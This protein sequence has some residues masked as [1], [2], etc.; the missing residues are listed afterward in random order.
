MPEAAFGSLGG[1]PEIW[2]I[3]FEYI[4]T[5]GNP[6]RPVCC[7]ALEYKSGREIRLWGDQL[8]VAPDFH[9]DSAFVCY[10][11]SAEVGCFLALNW[12]APVHVLD[13]FA[14]F[15]VLTNGESR[16]NGLTGSGLLDALAYFGLSHLDPDVKSHW[17]DRIMAGP[18]YTDVEAVGILDYCASD[19]Y[20]LRELLPRMQ[21]RLEGRPH[22][23]QHALLRGRYMI[24]AAKMES[25]GT[26]V[27][28][29]Q[30]NR[31]IANWEPLKLAFT[32]KIKAEYPI[33][34]G[35]TLKHDLFAGWLRGMR[36]PWPTTPSGRLSLSEDTFKQMTNAYPVIAPI[37]ELRDNLSKL[38]L[39]D[40]SIGQDGRNRTLLSAFRARTGR[41]QPSGTKFIFS[42][43]VWLRALIRPYQGYA[44]AYI[45]F[46]SHEIGIAAA[47]SRDP[48][49]IRS[50]TSGDPYLAFAKLAKLVPDNATRESHGGERDL[51]KSLLLGTLYGMGHETLAQNTGT[52]PA[53]ARELLY[54]H[55]N[56]YSTFWVW[57]QRT[58]D[59]ALLRGYIDTCFGWRL[60]ISSETR[61]TS[62]LNHPMQSHGAEMLRLACCFLNES[63]IS[64]CAPVHDAVLIE[65]PVDEIDEI[66]AKARALMGKASRIVLDGF[67]IR[68][69]VQVVRYPDAFFDKRGSDV[70]RRFASLLAEIELSSAVRIRH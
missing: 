42:P 9:Q 63:G 8:S 10:Y 29:A 15:R 62:L 18:P 25:V 52:S 14:E 33:F 46:S 7:V 66:V 47:L 48:E 49:M 6:P 68:T 55:R 20:A 58:I 11:A 51:C 36:I 50:Y 70:H 19:V 28:T 57:I 21:Q 24:A 32:E 3:D 13:L 56:T 43:S 17:R 61:H 26:P 22:W 40:I 31:F 27:D 4:A 41:N 67:E 1:F 5:P 53:F 45:D 39:N 59:V 34:D 37:R 65:G 69:D 54:K 64:V 30:M 35:S 2:L 38:R 23:L 12:L 16:L 60:A 44:L